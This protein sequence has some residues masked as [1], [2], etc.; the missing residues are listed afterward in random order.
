MR[1]YFLLWSLGSPVGIVTV[2]SKDSNFM[3]SKISIVGLGPTKL[4]IQ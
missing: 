2:G 3:F 4:A 1:K